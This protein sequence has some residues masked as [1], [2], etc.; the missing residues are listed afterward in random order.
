M[1]EQLSHGAENVFQAYLV[2]LKYFTF[3]KS[4]E[5]QILETNFLIQEKRS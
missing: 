4:G 3:M 5:E 1:D 2:T